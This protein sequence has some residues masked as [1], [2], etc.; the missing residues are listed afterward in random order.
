MTSRYFFVKVY[1]NLNWGC[2]WVTIEQSQYGD[3]WRKESCRVGQRIVVKKDVWWREEV[4]E[5]Q[6]R[7]E[8]VEWDQSS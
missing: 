7:R 2:V 6:E 4:W 5:E 3:P 8:S 1:A